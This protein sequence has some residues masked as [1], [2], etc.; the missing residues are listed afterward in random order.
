[1]HAKEWVHAIR[2]NAKGGYRYHSFAPLRADNEAKYYVGGKDY[3][4][5][6]AEA[7]PKANHEIYIAGWWVR[8][9]GV[10]FL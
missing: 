10:Y 2:A 6:L 3:Y 4:A 5:A 1:M 7:I 9:F 8:F